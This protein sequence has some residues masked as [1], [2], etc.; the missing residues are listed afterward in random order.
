MKLPEVCTLL[1]RQLRSQPQERVPEIEDTAKPRGTG[2]TCKAT[3]ATI[4]DESG[5]FL[6]LEGSCPDK[7]KIKKSYIRFLLYN[8]V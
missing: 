2:C 8:V 7:Y 6:F 4:Q 1:E 5:V 3:A